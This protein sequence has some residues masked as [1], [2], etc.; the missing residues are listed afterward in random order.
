MRQAVNMVIALV[1]ASFLTPPAWAVIGDHFV[2]GYKLLQICEEGDKLGA[3]A[4]SA[5]RVL[6]QA[7]IDR[8]SCYAYIEGVFDGIAD[9]LPC[10]LNITLGQIQTIVVNYLK[11]HPAELHLPAAGLGSTALDNAID[12]DRDRL[13][14]RQQ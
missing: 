6:A 13:C 3:E 4:P 7:I 11:M 12:R 2:D 9:D 14:K 5:N 10:S 8:A 1:Q